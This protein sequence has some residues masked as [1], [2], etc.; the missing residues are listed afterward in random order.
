MNGT[1]TSGPLALHDAALLTD[2]YTLTM[3][4][5]YHREGMRGRATFSLF[6]RSLPRERGFLVAAG[7]EDAL[8]FLADF[9]F[10]DDAVAHLASRAAGAFD[11]AFVESLRGMRFTGD[12]RA[13][14]E[15]TVVFPNEPLVEITAPLVEAQ[16]VEAAV[17]NCL[18]YQTAIATKAARA[19]LSARGRPVSEF[20]LRRAPGTDAAMKAARSSY[21][22]GAASTSNVLAGRTYGIPVAGTM[23]HAYVEAFP[24]ELTAFRAFVAAFPYGATLLIDTYDTLTGARRAAQVARELAER[25]GRLGAVRIDGGDL[26]WLSAEVRRILDDAGLR[27]VRV[28]ASGGLDEYD[29]ARLVDAGAPIDGFGVGTKMDVSADAPYLEMVYKL[30][31]YDGRDVIKASAGKT[32]LAGEKQ[33]WRRLGAD[34]RLAGDTIGRRDERDDAHDGEPLLVPVMLD[35]RRVDSAPTLAAARARCAAQLA[36]LPDGVKRL[37]DA[38][39]YPVSLSDA[40]AAHQRDV[41]AR[42]TEREAAA[43][44]R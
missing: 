39:P 12:V 27:D 32:T 7:L 11:S 13:V 6:V 33:V 34:G 1:F 37:R 38:E 42:V 17:M 15:G 14:P 16:V 30:V 10:G 31:R 44:S 35:G 26:A 43:R 2:L 3:A 4:A 24:T 19:V 41:V 20:G 5:S 40:L 28:F 9:T 29:I 21:L 8:A 23:A 18:H 22:A 36:A 25:G